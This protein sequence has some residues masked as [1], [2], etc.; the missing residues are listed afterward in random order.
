MSWR[1]SHSRRSKQLRSPGQGRSQKPAAVART[2]FTPCCTS[3]GR[4]A[5]VHGCGVAAVT[6]V[7]D[8]VVVLWWSQRTARR[9]RGCL[10]STAESHRSVTRHCVVESHLTRSAVRQSVPGQ[11]LIT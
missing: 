5:A 4:I 9:H 7:D 10:A 1:A 3:T 8:V 11:R 2:S 6:D